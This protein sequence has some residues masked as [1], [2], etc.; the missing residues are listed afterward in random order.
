MLK[1]ILLLAVLLISLGSTMSLAANHWYYVGTNGGVSFY[2]D[3]GTVQKNDKA[4][5]VW[6]KMRNSRGHEIWAHEIWAHF[7]F[8]RYDKTYTLT[9]ERIGGRSRKVNP[10][11]AIR[12]IIPNTPIEKIL[13]LI[14]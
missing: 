4:A 8:S 10:K 5:Y 11:T 2:I 13:N 6:V 1:R 7:I 14:W 9:E 3:N 12:P